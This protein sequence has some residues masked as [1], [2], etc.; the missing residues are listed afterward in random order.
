MN[1][2][3]Y[4]SDY[5]ADSLRW[6]NKIIELNLKP[7]DHV[8]LEKFQDEII[9]AN[10]TAMAYFF[11]TEFSYKVWRMQKLIL[12]KKDPKYAFIFALTVPNADI[13]VL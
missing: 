4:E 2:H 7:S 3:V 6:L 12:D 8:G 11:A 13:K 10:D 1:K 9:V 5:S